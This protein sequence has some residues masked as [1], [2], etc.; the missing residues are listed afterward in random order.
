MNQDSKKTKKNYS[1]QEKNYLKKN[2]LFKD[3]IIDSHS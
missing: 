1:L 3:N 2:G